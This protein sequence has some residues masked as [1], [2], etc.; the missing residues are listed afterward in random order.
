MGL[1]CCKEGEFRLKMQNFSIADFRNHNKTE[2]QC[3]SAINVFLGNNGEG[4]TNILE[5]IS[6]LCLSKSFFA[7]SDELV[8][9][10]GTD[11]FVVIGEIVTDG[12][13]LFEVR[14]EFD[15]NQCKKSITVNRGRIEKAS[16]LIGM[17]PVVILAPNQN[18]ISTGASSARRKFIDLI[19][20]Q[21][22]RKYLE[23]LMEYRKVLRQR[24]R[25]LAEIAGR[26]NQRDALEPW[27]KI[28]I[29]T[30]SEITVKRRQFIE[31]F[32]RSFSDAYGRLAGQGEKPSM[33]YIPSIDG[34]C[35]VDIDQVQS[36]FAQALQS[37]A[38]EEI[39][40]GY[41]LVGPHRDEICFT[42]NDL[43]VRSYASQG[44]H[45]TILVA[46]KLAEF[47]Y[48][49]ERCNETPILLLDDAFSELDSQRVQGLLANTADFG[50]VF[51]TAT[52]DTNV[53]WKTV[54]NAI[55]RRFFVRQG[56]IERIEDGGAGYEIG[57]RSS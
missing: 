3:S 12:G 19:I 6:Y 11:G 27:N 22:S 35:G 54:S 43:D 45:K 46:L 15:K 36:F 56:C 16:L 26:K 55:P 49:K 29:T 38:D 5:G 13:V 34:A 4:K 57:T 48:L 7:V 47:L 10:L 31:D 1:S 21:A 53:D 25:V 30:G 18:T 9:R 42:I 23:V 37:R 20:S 44:Q 14:V 33:S 8:V 41:S 32:K 50:Q 40:L 24:N 39:R 17:F 51:L 28:L 2:V 52:D